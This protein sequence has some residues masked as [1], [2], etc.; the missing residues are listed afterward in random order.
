MLIFFFSLDRYTLHRRDIIDHVQD[1]YFVSEN[2]VISEII[3]HYLTI[4]DTNEKDIK[5]TIVFFITHLTK[6][7]SNINLES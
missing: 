2:C 5:G 1:T 3:K 7:M 4:N 6:K